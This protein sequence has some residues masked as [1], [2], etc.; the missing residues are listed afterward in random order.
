MTH[1]HPLTNVPLSR[2]LHKEWL[3]RKFC[4]EDQEGPA[5]KRTKLWH[6]AFLSISTHLTLRILPALNAGRGRGCRAS[7]APPRTQPFLASG[8]LSHNACTK[9]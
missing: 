1:R 2:R 7:K 5:R 4:S 8:N 9:T 6:V 3:C